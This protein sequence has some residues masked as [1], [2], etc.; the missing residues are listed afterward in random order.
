MYVRRSKKQFILHSECLFSSKSYE[1]SV[2]MRFYIAQRATACVSV[3][4][5]DLYFGKNAKDKPY[6]RVTFNCIKG[7]QINAGLRRTIQTN[8]NDKTLCFYEAIRD[9]LKSEFEI[10]ADEFNNIKD[11]ETY[12]KKYGI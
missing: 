4:F 6:V 9:Y 3:L 1:K 2:F 5:E 11:S 7:V 8:N 12:R 10:S